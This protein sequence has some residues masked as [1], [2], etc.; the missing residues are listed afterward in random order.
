MMPLGEDAHAPLAWKALHAVLE[1]NES[2]EMQDLRDR[3]AA[4]LRDTLQQLT[5]Q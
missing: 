5:Q 2:A 4:P 3:E 1:V